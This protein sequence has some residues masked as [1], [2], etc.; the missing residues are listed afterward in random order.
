VKVKAEHWIFAQEHTIQD[1][2][3]EIVSFE[4]RHSSD[5]GHGNDIRAVL[6][7]K[8]GRFFCPWLCDI[9][10]CS[11]DLELTSGRNERYEG[12]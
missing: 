6:I 11:Q 2:V 3:G 9:K 10:L 1:F 4:P 7:D 12:L 5:I 8:D